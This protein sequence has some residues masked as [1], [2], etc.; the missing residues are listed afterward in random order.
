MWK[1]APRL[2]EVEGVLPTSARSDRGSPL[3]AR[4]SLQKLSTSEFLGDEDTYDIASMSL[5]D[6]TA[7][8]PDYAL[9]KL[10]RFRLLN[11]CTQLEM[12]MKLAIL[13]L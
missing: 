11:C 3:R 2:K 9:C 4:K 7:G 13:D 5:F 1:K 12:V 8:A 10:S 6:V